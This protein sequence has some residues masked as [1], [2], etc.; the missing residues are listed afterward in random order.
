[1]DKLQLLSVHVVHVV[2]CNISCTAVHRSIIYRIYRDVNAVFL[3]NHV[4]LLLTSARVPHEHEGW[5]CTES[6]RR[7]FLVIQSRCVRVCVLS[8]PRFA[9]A[10]LLCK[11]AGT[12]ARVACY[13]LRIAPFS[14]TLQARFSHLVYASHLNILCYEHLSDAHNQSQH[15]NIC[16]YTVLLWHTPR[17]Y[18]RKPRYLS[19]LSFTICCGATRTSK[20]PASAGLTSSVQ[21]GSQT[22][23]RWLGRVLPSRLYSLSVQGSEKDF[24]LTLCTDL[25]SN[26]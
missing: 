24:E 18:N 15:K 2:L 23:L 8:I 21:V 25:H 13:V 7:L 6:N 17:P 20:S 10:P 19:S 5:S 12:Y 26:C 22:V 11:H 3:V 4:E 14:N 9:C 16:N 1:M